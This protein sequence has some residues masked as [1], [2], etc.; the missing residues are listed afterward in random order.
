[1]STRALI[2]S[3]VFSFAALLASAQS[4]LPKTTIAGHE[5]YYYDTS[6]GE[7]IYSIASK[8][9]VTKDEII[10]NNPDAADGISRQ[11]RQHQQPNRRNILSSTKSSRERP[12]TALPRPTEPPSMS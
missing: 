7:S 4:N 10:K 11:R 1:M 2:A 9:G 6:E 5:Y 12:S 3:L 8:L